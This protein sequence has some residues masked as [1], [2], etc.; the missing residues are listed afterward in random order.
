[1]K[2][3][4]I[5]IVLFSIGMLSAFKI[6]AQSIVRSTGSSYRPRPEVGIRIAPFLQNDYTV[7]GAMT[8]ISFQNRSKRFGFRYR[9]NY[10]KIY[11]SNQNIKEDFSSYFLNTA[12]LT[13]EALYI[14]NDEPFQLSLGFSK[15]LHLTKQKTKFPYTLDFSLGQHI[16]NF[17]FEIRITNFMSYVPKPVYTWYF[18]KPQFYF[19]VGYMINIQR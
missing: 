2:K 18:F 6:Q 7:L 13:Y 11:N 10:M 14:S 5:F 16:R 15:G 9:V 4:I 17:I 8:G 12:E 3:H 19:G 1:M